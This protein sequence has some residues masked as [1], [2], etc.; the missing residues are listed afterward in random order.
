MRRTGLLVLALPALLAAAQPATTDMSLVTPDGFVLKGTLTIPANPGRRPVVLLAHEYQADR[1]G[2]QVLADNLNA[3]G[4]ATLALDLRGHGQSTHRGEATVAVTPD[5]LASSSAVGFDRIPGDLAQA[6]Q[7]LRKQP[8]L[9]GTRLGLAGSSLGAYA[10]LA[11]APLVRPV[12]ILALSP[13]GGWGQQPGLRL[14]RALEQ[15]RTS[16]FVLAS[17][18]DPEALANAT[19]IKGVFGVYAR[20]TP[21]KEHGFAF[22]PGVTDLLGGWLGE[23]LLRQPGARAGKPR[24]TPKTEAAMPTEDVK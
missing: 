3:R 22:L 19:A 9:D 6:A 2:W 15:A 16:V 10:A 5:F 7:W 1:S 14:A 12:A 23:T 11:A 21:G 20:I 17:E 13:A 8:R 18:E 24:S 4:I